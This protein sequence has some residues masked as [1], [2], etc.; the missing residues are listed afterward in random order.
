[1]K[2]EHI[3]QLLEN[4][5]IKNAKDGEM[6]LDITKQCSG[7]GFVLSGDIRFYRHSDEGREIT[8][9]HITRGNMCILTASCYLGKG[10]I[11]YPVGAVAET[12]SKILFVSFDIFGKLFSESEALRKYFFTAMAD[13]LYN[14]MDVIDGV[15]FR[16]VNSRLGEYILKKT[17]GGKHP[18]YA[19]HSEIARDI[20]SAREVVSR[21]LKKLEKEEMVKLHRGKLEVSDAKRLSLIG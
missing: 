17:M 20:G 16:S 3:R 10:Y 14:V 19:T 4:S 18:L 15:A 12:A 13:R 21:L 11:D 7:I 1:M 8:L 9:Y 2:N 6:I 5:I